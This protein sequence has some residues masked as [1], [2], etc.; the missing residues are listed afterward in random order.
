MT[1]GDF[2]RVAGNYHNIVD[3]DIDEAPVD[4]LVLGPNVNGNDLAARLRKDILRRCRAYGVGIKAEHP[5]LRAVAEKKLGKLGSLC[6]YEMGLAKSSDAVV[7]VAA[8]PG[9][10]A[11]FG[12]FAMLPKM[13]AR[14]LVLLDRKHENE[15]SYLK[16]GPARSMIRLGGI[17]R[18]VYYAHRKKVWSVVEEHIM[19]ARERKV[20][21]RYFQGAAR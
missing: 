5:E 19:D 13:D 21:A 15:E 20:N 7:I 14:I 17:V 8:S 3:A 9:S 18:W 10:F 16:L 12:L 1:D 4:V 11:E 2:G 6:T